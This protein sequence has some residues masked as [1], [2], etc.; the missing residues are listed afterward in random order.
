[1]AESKEY[2]ARNELLT[3]EDSVIELFIA[4]TDHKSTPAP[5]SQPLRKPN[6]AYRPQRGASPDPQ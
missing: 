3:S 5:T 1:M 2:T 4:K 6:P